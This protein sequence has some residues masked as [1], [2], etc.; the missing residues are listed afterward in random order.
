MD[1]TNTYFFEV[2]AE[3]RQI[4]ELRKYLYEHLPSYRITKAEIITNTTTMNDAS[5]IKRLQSIPFK[6]LGKSKA[7]ELVKA[8]LTSFGSLLP[9]TPA[10]IIIEP[11]QQDLVQSV[12][13]E[14]VLIYQP[15]S[16]YEDLRIDLYLEWTPSYVI[17]Q[18]KVLENT[19]ELNDQE[20][21]NLLLETSF[22]PKSDK[23]KTDKPTFEF[24]LSSQEQM[25]TPESFR[26]KGNQLKPS[27]PEDILY[28]PGIGEELEVIGTLTWKNRLKIS[29][30]VIFT[31]YSI[32][33]NIYEITIETN[34]SVGRSELKKAI[35]LILN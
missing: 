27:I 29:P 22:N 30:I 13:D 10:Q 12:G 23:L 21:T 7:P 25:I 19:T 14:E 9:L 4:L 26:I 11:G 31:H 2:E 16:I 6:Y 17:D 24:S 28:A 5:L 18:I 15:S 32:A 34:G 1:Q 3:I 20:I 33:E 35:K 8:T